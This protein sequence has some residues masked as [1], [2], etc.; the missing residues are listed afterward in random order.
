MALHARCSEIDALDQRLEPAKMNAIEFV[1]AAQRQSDAMK[2]HRVIGAQIEELVQRHS[3]GHVILGMHLE[4][5][6][7]RPGCGDPRHM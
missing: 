4:K 7:L 3:L 2:A 5:A 1:G 6:K